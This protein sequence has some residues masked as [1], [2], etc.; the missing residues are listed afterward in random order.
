M[1]EQTLV[2]VQAVTEILVLCLLIAAWNAARVALGRLHALSTLI[3]GA[4][5][6]SFLRGALLCAGLRLSAVRRHRDPPLTQAMSFGPAL[7]GDAPDQCPTQKQ[8]RAG[9]YTSRHRR[10]DFP[11]SLISAAQGSLTAAVENPHVQPA[12]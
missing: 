3:E 9:G 10:W 11:G 12:S 4:L 1:A 6:V 5:L 8:A 2:L 7:R